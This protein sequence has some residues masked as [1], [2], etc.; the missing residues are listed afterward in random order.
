MLN[1]L[2]SLFGNNSFNLKEIIKN[3]AILVDVRTPSEYAEAQIKGAVNI[4]LDQLNN[5]ISQL[6]DKNHIIVFCRSGYRSSQA[7]ALLE[8]KGFTNVINAGTWIKVK[9]ELESV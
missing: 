5:R 6:K 8:A 7:K 9:R 3:N 1:L 4:P 2:K